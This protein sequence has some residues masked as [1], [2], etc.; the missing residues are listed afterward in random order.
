MACA[1]PSSSQPQPQ[2]G[3]PPLRIL[4]ET[5]APY[6]VPST[7]YASPALKDIKGRLP[8]SHSAM[9]PW[10]AQFVA[11]VANRARAGEGQG[12][13]W[14]VESVLEEGRRNAKAVYGI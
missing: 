3:L 11:G 4:L 14:D 5:D 1:A 8:L 12:E 13:V 10:T 6:M 2:S 9:I 7:I